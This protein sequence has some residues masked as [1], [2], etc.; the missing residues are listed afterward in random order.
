VKTSDQ[1]TEIA[2]A[3]VKVQSSMAPAV[4]ESTNAHFKS[5]YADLTAVWNACRKP[6]T[7]NGLSVWQDVTSPDDGVAVTTRIVHTSGQWIEFGPLVVPLAKKDAHG[8]GSA[9][10]YAKR[11]GLAAAVG[12]TTDDDDGNE[13]AKGAHGNGSDPYVSAKQA[14]DLESLADEVKADKPKFLK[15]IKAESFEKIPA[16]SH[17]E[18]VR[19]LEAKRTRQ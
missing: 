17:A 2:A 4:K 13:A 10:S 1:I 14:A 7:D 3:M 11:Y 9:T 5:K 15:F 8:V 6:L 16:K 18:C 19:Q 12:V